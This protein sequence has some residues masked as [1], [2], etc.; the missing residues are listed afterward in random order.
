MLARSEPEICA[1]AGA[2]VRTRN[3][4][5]GCDAVRSAHLSSSAKEFAQ[6]GASC[7]LG[8]CCASGC[9]ISRKVAEEGLEQSANTPGKTA[10]APRGRAKSDVNKPSLQRLA[11]NQRP[12][13]TKRR[14]ARATGDAETDF[15]LALVTSIARGCFGEDVPRTAC[16][17]SE[18]VDIK[19]AAIRMT[20]GPTT[21]LLAGV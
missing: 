18:V 7:G 4:A 9:E 5:I 14:R 1:A 21:L 15:A 2:A 20:R 3:V 19:R 8:R 13:G 17:S 6:A 12:F 16:N 10:L 11:D